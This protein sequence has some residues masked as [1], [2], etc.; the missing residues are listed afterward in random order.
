M[1]PSMYPCVSPHA[2]AIERTHCVPP[3]QPPLLSS[4]PVL[5]SA[6]VWARIAAA[7]PSVTNCGET[8]KTGAMEL[9]QD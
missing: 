9:R 4:S 3:V 8:M 7:E 2:A 6:G 5:P 1:L